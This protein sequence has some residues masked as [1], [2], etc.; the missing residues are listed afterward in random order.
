MG[1]KNYTIS[2]SDLSIAVNIS[3]FHV[4]RLGSKLCRLL[5]FISLPDSGKL[6]VVMYIDRVTYEPSTSRVIFSTSVEFCDLVPVG[7]KMYICRPAHTARS[8][9]FEIDGT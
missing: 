5:G 6:K 1:T 8:A 7:V 9:A 4:S 2:R 3:K